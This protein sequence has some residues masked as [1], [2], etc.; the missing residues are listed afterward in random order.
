[1]ETVIS[2]FLEM[3]LT[4]AEGFEIFCFETKLVLS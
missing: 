4:A 2:V 3:I 1:M